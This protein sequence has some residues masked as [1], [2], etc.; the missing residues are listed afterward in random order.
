MNVSLKS[1]LLNTEWIPFLQRKR[2]S[3]L[4]IPKSELTVTKACSAYR[5]QVLIRLALSAT[6]PNPGTVPLNSQTER[7]K[8]LRS[9]LT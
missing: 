3:K 4:F 2:K 1:K 7:G 6:S 8:K 5:R 9:P